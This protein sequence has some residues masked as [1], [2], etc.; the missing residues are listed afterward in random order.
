M[1]WLMAS[2]YDRVMRRME[3]EYGHRWRREL[4]GDLHGDVLEIGAGT[5]RNLDHYRDVDRLVLAEPDVH[6]RRKL[7]EKVN[8]V[9]VARSIEVVPWSAE[10]LA[11]ASG[12]F[13]VIV[14]TLV[15]CS[16]CDPVES[17]R[18]VRSALRPDG[19]FVFLE[20]VAASDPRQY[21]WQK[22]IEP[23]WKRV[24]GNC[25]LC[26]HTDHLMGE[27][28]FQIESLVRESTNIVFPVVTESIRG[29]ARGHSSVAN[30]SL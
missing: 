2:V 29:V 13:D 7:I 4:V 10:K 20:H 17:L 11:C 9:N 19:K 14:C 16:V 26:R 18:Q 12:S 30:R 22:R 27:A 23:I 28:G 8:R 5:G 25:H 21:A 3:S 6:M 1:S 24:A 15:L